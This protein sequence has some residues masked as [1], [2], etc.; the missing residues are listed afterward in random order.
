[1]RLG[2]KGANRV[3]EATTR[4]PSAFL[5]TLG[6]L[7]TYAAALLWGRSAGLVAALV[8]STSFEWRQA[9]TAARVDMTLTFVLLCSFFFFFTFTVREAVGRNL[10][11]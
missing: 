9:A 10:F 7:L 4:F 8:L 5:G 3:D 11:S 1:L 2:I 6:V